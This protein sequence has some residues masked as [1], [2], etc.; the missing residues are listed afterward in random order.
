MTEITKTNATELDLEEMRQLIGFADCQDWNLTGGLSVQGV[1]D[2]Y[3]ASSKYISIGDWL[4]DDPQAEKEFNA[5]HE[6]FKAA[7]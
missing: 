5:I 4:Y 3:H 1:L 6:K 2:I 7:A